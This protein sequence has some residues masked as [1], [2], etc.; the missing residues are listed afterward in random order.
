MLKRYESFRYVKG[1]DC[2]VKEVWFKIF[3]KK[4][5]WLSE[6]LYLAILKKQYSVSKLLSFLKMLSAEYYCFASFIFEIFYKFPY[7]SSWLDIKP[8]SYFV[9]DQYG[10]TTQ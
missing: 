8:R 2:N 5:I 4:L 10:F 7:L 1:L 6:I 3:V 9:K